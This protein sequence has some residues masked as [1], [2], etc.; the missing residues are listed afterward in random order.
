MTLPLLV[1]ASAGT[2][3]TYRL[4]RE[5]VAALSPESARRARVDGL[6]AVTYT[7]KAQAELSGRIRRALVQAGDFEHANHLPMAYVGTVH[8]TC[9]RFLEELALDAGLPPYLEVLPED[10]GQRL[11]AVLEDRVAP[12]TREHLDRLARR[13][14]ICFDSR[15]ARHDWPRRA[16]EVM[17][18]ARGNR[19]PPEALPE[20][21]RRSITGLLE[22]LG[23]PLGSARELD[24][25]FRDEVA[26]SI[27][28]LDTFDDGTAKTR[29]ARARLQE[30]HARVAR[31]D[32]R[33][34]DWARAARIAP[35]V[36]CSPAVEP[37][38]AVATQCVRH[39]SLHDDLRSFT[40]L[41]FE[42]ASTALVG[43]DR[44]KRA[45]RIVDYVDMVDQ[46]LHL[47]GR[48]HIAAELADRLDLI[49]VDEFQDTSP[50]QLAFFTALHGM[51][52]RSVWVGDGKQCIFEYAGA[53]PLLMDAVGRWIV[54]EG[55]ATER[56]AVNY[57]SRPELVDACCSLFAPV[58][59]DVRVSPGRS[60]TAELAPTPPL[61]VWW[62][63]TR[64]AAE[65]AE[66]IADAAARLLREE[67]VTPVYDGTLDRVRP[68][69]PRDVGILVATNVEAKRIAAGLHRR[70]VRA[71]LARDGLLA[72][73]EGTLVESA[74]RWLVEPSDRDALARLEALGG[75][76]GLP[77]DQWLERQLTDPEPELPAWLV[78]LRELR[79]RL[80]TFAPS[81][82][83]DEVM[84]ALDVATMCARWP[85]AQQRIGNLDSLRA[86]AHRY[87]ERCRRQGAPAT[88]AGL[89]RYFDESRQVVLVKDE[90][91]ATDDQFAGDD[92]DAVTICTYHRAKGLEWPVVVLGSL[93]RG[94]KRDPF[95]PCPE[96]D[97]PDF[98]P[99]TPLEGRWIRFW[100]WPFG[101]QT[102]LPLADAAAVSA[103]GR[104]VADRELRERRRLLYVGFTRARDHLILAARLTKRG[105][106]T[107]WLDDVC[108]PSGQPLLTLPVAPDP[109]GPSTEGS[110]TVGGRALRCRIVRASTGTFERS[111]QPTPR[112]LARGGPFQ[113]ERASYRITPSS[114]GESYAPRT[115]YAVHR[116]RRI[117]SAVALPR[118]TDWAVLGTA[119]HAFLAADPYDDAAAR[120]VTAR[121]LLANA[122][123]VGVITP[124]RLLGVSDALRATICARWPDAR[125][126][127]ETPVTAIVEDHG[128]RRRI[129][130][131]IDL[132][133]ELPDGVVV[134]D[135]KTYPSP[136][137]NAVVERAADFL[138][139]LA[140]YADALTACGRRILHAA[141]HLPCAGFWLDVA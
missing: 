30:I 37:L 77:P 124:E 54:R 49:V 115:R 26:A 4:T 9:M 51:T 139:Q 126:L 12:A 94:E 98:D 88:A 81:E 76:S 61:G 43:Y 85:H 46:A 67:H 59:D 82:M 57:R 116:V 89:V 68:V 104:R 96:S 72:T 20:M 107:A 16:A 134:V 118:G 66:A 129:E 79:A 17:D 100:P 78:P 34:I 14:E 44:W 130:G 23:P 25:R 105:P 99:R 86:L 112:R 114:A 74:L 73:P 5:V 62:L 133:L 111:A 11:R 87:E 48:P 138:P 52:Q 56:L 69:E 1:T 127:R 120:L 125:W 103:D 31:D 18:L 21:A 75:W 36:R 140:T 35:S 80:D 91:R 19:I 15:T 13:L 109:E 27:Q 42:A 128:G 64:N 40:Q 7:R 24:E 97:R 71:T 47:V 50:L 122:G 90:E 70:G 39:P 132:L 55:G 135:H 83:L 63:E 41:L 92:T 65:D 141:L 2:G 10:G 38:V 28:R 29:D 8:A 84:S 95:T 102:D 33:W 110:A 136:S 119:V 22:L 117:S 123:F 121:R 131:V 53:D 108:D 32:V 93:D 3:K 113:E 101:Q 106:K 60:E 45:R 6:V 58:L 137:D